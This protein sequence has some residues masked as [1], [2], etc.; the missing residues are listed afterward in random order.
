MKELAFLIA[1]K[2][3]NDNNEN[4]IMICGQILKQEFI[5][6]GY[7][8]INSNTMAVDTLKIIMKTMINIG[9]NL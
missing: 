8:Q 9:E 6:L 1:E 5:N 4:T 2:I 3:A 7:N